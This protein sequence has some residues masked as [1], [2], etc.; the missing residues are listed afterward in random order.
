ME[1][2]GKVSYIKKPFAKRSLYSVG[3]ILPALVCMVLGIR[4]AVV[5]KGEIPVNM[6][7]VCL[8]SFI[9]SFAGFL[10]GVSSFREKE[11]NYLLSKI[12]TVVNC[13]MVIIW[14]VM[15]IAGLRG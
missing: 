2:Q 11:K 13:L 12:G 14:V 8:A 3:L 6:A 15:M 4:S 1:H 5:T 9:W 7:A 10:Y